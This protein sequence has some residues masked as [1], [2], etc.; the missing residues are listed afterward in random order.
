MQDTSLTPS[1]TAHAVVDVILLHVTTEGSAPPTGSNEL[2]SFHGFD[3]GTGSAG[4]TAGY[5]YAVDNNG[6]VYAFNPASP[7]Q[8][9]AFGDSNFAFGIAV[10]IRSTP[11]SS[12]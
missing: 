7:T 6:N 10:L 12:P 3:T 11:I 4:S 5:T 2:Y 1:V 8:P 9:P